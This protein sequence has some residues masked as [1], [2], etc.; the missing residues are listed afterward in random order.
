MQR[1]NIKDSGAEINQY[2]LFI[3]LYYLLAPMEDILTGKFGTVAKY[4]AII[5]VFFGFVNN[6][7]GITLKPST[8]SNCIIY[9]T[10]LSVASCIWA[11]DRSVAM[12][13]NVAYLLVPGLAWFV[14]QLEFSAKEKEYI[15]TASI[16]GGLLTVGYLVLKG[17][18]NI[19]GVQRMQLTE[20]N[21]QNNFA[22]LL[23]L[24]FSLCFIR[25]FGQNLKKSTLYI[26][27]AL[28]FA[29]MILMTGSRGALLSMLLFLMVYILFSQGKKRVRM[30][31]CALIALVIAY[32]VILPLL[33][34]SLRSRL[35]DNDSYTRTINSEEN[36][37]AFWKLAFT[38]IIPKNLLLGVGS[39]CT[40][41]WLGKFFSRNRGMHNTYIN[42]LC[43]YGILGL[44]VFLGM[45]YSLFIEK[46]R[47]G[48]AAE[49]AQL[50]GICLIILFLD[51]YP[52]KFFWNIITLLM[53]DVKQPVSNSNIYLK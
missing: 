9:L 6:N 34:E 25:A 2:T 36:R 37:I 45:L 16:V 7:G 13:R 39:G 33:P 12:H 30:L 32:F 31:V 29:Y 4:L 10:V 47:Q 52:K 8:A 50:A 48:N 42:M 44:P 19:T 21:D 5:I 41:L 15:I 17:Q 24:P 40:P 23:Y 1:R 22:A 14:G 49:I 3:M 11:T 38:E 46:K 35:F 27:F 20:G 53:I 43:E 28:L 18:I 26:G 51:A